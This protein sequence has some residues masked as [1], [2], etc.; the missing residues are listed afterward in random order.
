MMLSCLF[1]RDASS[2]ANANPRAVI[3]IAVSFI[4]GG[5]VNTGVFIGSR[6]AVINRP[7]IMLPHAKRFKGLITAGSFSLMGE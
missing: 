6:L 5:M 2:S 7:A 4:R 1:V 3:I